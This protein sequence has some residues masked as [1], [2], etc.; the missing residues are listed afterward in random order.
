MSAPTQAAEVVSASARVAAVA[1]DLRAGRMAL[2]SGGV[3][4][5][6][7]ASLVLAAEFTSAEAINFMA[8]EARGLICLALS[9]ERCDQLGLEPISRPGGGD[10]ESGFMVSIE[11]REGVTTGISAHDRSRTIRTAVDPTQGPMDLVQPGHV[12]PLRARRGGIFERAGQAEAA[13]DLAR[14]AG[15]EPAA[16]VCTVLDEDGA[17]A[18]ATGLV[19]YARRYNLN[20]VSVDDLLAHRRSA[21]LFGGTMREAMGHFAT[22]VG[23][24]TARDGEG[25]TVGTTVNA[26]SSVSLQPP[27]LLVCLARDSHTLSA[28]RESSRFAINILAAD[29]HHHSNRFAAKGAEARAGEVPFAEHPT[30]VPHL[31]GSL[32]TLSCRLDAIHVAGDHEIVIGEALSI[33][34]DADASP[35]LFYRGSYA[36]L[37]GEHEVELRAVS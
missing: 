10:A 13:V 14:L 6:D 32:A 23:V 24:V 18:T 1:A 8:K 4:R 28:I 34:T 9:A 17:T 30:G 12:M 19:D 5:K 35:L 37:G 21:A 7:E 31:P 3:G 22:G 29:Q 33:S 20:T 15:T 11:S 27:L 16:I 2:L 36:S 25:E 26:V